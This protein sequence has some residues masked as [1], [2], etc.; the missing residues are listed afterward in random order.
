MS[1][2]SQF[3]E[4]AHLLNIFNEIGHRGKLCDIG[5][6]LGG[7]NSRL[8]IEEHGYTGTLVDADERHVE[9]I[10]NKLQVKRKING[11][12]VVC[13]KVTIDTIN[14]HVGDADFLSIDIDSNDWWVWAHVRSKP[15]VVIVEFNRKLDGFRICDYDEH[16]TKCNGRKDD[17]SGSLNAFLLLGELK[18]Y[19]HIGTTGP[20]AIFVDKDC[21]CEYRA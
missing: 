7:S 13:E 16:M 1:K 21:H 6:R 10:V 11:L 17:E 15:R 2:Y 4:E 5:A 9:D 12:N 20:N 14:N 19:D 8:L 3:Q 18:G